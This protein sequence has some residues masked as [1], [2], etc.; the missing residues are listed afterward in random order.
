MRILVIDDDP[1]MTQL[2]SLTLQGRGHA[3]STADC[4]A[5]ALQKLSE[6]APHLVLLD[7]GL[8][9]IPGIEVARRFRA[10]DAW[11]D[12]K[13]L[14]LTASDSMSDI[15]L[16]KANGVSGYLCKPIATET[17]GE[18]VDEVL[19]EADLLWIDDFTRARRAV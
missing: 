2:A 13:I 9:D 14:M 10:V 1:F 19:G 3:V 8:P 16:A 12:T 7:L 4:G 18:R 6:P 5:A 15:V 11:R 17:L